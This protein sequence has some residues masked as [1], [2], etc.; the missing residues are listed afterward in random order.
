MHRKVPSSHWDYVMKWMSP[1]LVRGESLTTLSDSY[2]FCCL[3]WEVCAEKEP[4]PGMQSKSISQ[5]WFNDQGMYHG[6]CVLPLNNNIPHYLVPLLELGLQPD[7]GQR[8]DF[9]LKWILRALRTKQELNSNGHSS[10]PSLESKK[11][12]KAMVPLRTRGLSPPKPTR[13]KSS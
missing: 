10:Q 12:A 13:V 2:S 5:M 9:N 11:E 7:I 3:V 6:P 1:E 8:R 4:W